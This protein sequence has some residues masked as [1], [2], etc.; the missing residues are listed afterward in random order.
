MLNPMAEWGKGYLGLSAW[1]SLNE[2]CL[3]GRWGTQ[4]GGLA[5]VVQSDD[6]DL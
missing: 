1:S 4:D 6:D 3:V 5:G 2:A